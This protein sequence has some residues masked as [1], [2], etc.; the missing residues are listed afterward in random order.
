[1]WVRPANLFAGPVSPHFPQAVSSSTPRPSQQHGD[2]VIPSGARDLLLFFRNA[3]MIAALSFNLLG[4][5]WRDCLDPAP[6]PNS[7]SPTSP[8]DRTR[9]IGTLVGLLTRQMSGNDF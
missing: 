8:A 7:K 1:M 6:K 9:H 4:D 3:L 5:A 2:V